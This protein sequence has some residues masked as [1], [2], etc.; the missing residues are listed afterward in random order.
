MRK[1]TQGRSG[2]G[3]RQPGP[4]LEG[5]PGGLVLAESHRGGGTVK[6]PDPGH[7]GHHLLEELELLRSDL[8]GELLGQPRD[9]AAG[10]D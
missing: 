3:F 1:Q 5:L 8:S 9:V 6:H 4:D 10:P 2:Y 7:L